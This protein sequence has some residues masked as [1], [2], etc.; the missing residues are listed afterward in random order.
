MRHQLRSILIATAFALAMASASTVV[1]APVTWNQVDVTLHAEQGG[2]VLLVSG[3]LPA[4]A[5]LPAEAELSVPTGAKLQWIGEILGGPASEDPE[6]TYT[7]VTKDGVDVYR[8]TLTKARTAQAEVLSSA[9]G[10][11]GTTFTPAIKWTSAQDVPTVRLNVRVPEGAQLAETPPGVTPQPAGDGFT[12]YSKTAQN[13]KAGD[14]LSLAFAYT[15]PAGATAARPAAGSAAGSSDGPVLAVIL[16]G[17][18]V[19]AIAVV[20]VSRRKPA[21]LT[22]AE[23]GV[24][25]VEAAEDEDDS[26]DSQTHA[27]AGRSA[28]AGRRR[29]V[30]GLIIG[31]LVVGAIVV[32]S[33]SGKPKMIGDT[34]TETFAQGDPCVTANIAV[35][36]PAG[37]DPAQ[38]AETL[39]GALRPVSGLKSA[40][41]NVKTSSMQ[42]GF[43]ESQTSETAVRGAL[44]P[45]GL[46]AQ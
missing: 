20:L 6:L 9:A 2:G 38:A 5:A 21:P 26:N 28:G 32:G 8:F 40:T 1:A 10:Y 19:V 27:P 4:K 13:V 35:A 7:K 17:I 30:T 3:E 46:I 18:A 37:T 39:F 15:A 14:E 44:A 43:C 22:S 24:N 31:G 42:V 16:A 23:E 45:T 36:L 34:V 33:Q 12:F 29:L 11:D 41:L 25:A